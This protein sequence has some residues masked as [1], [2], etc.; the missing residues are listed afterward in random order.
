M[1][2]AVAEMK[3]K[4]AIDALGLAEAY[5]ALEKIADYIHIAK[6]GM[7]EQ[8]IEQAK[9]IKN[10]E[11]MISQEQNRIDQTNLQIKLNRNNTEELLKL[12]KVLEREKGKMEAI[13]EFG[14]EELFAG[15]ATK[16]ARLL[17]H[18]DSTHKSLQDNIKASSIWNKTLREVGL[19]KIADSAKSL[20]TW[21]GQ[22][23]LWA[24]MFTENMR[25]AS[26]W[27]DQNYELYGSLQSVANGVRNVQAKAG[28][29]QKEAEEAAKAV[30]EM[31]VDPKTFE[32][33]AVAVGTFAAST[34]VSADTTARLYKQM[35]ASGMS[36]KAMGQQY[37]TLRGAMAKYGLSS[38]DAGVMVKYLTDNHYQLLAAAGGSETRLNQMTAQFAA[39]AGAAKAAGMDTST[40]VDIFQKLTTDATQFV[41]LLGKGLMANNPAEMFLQ[42]GA[43]AEKVINQIKKMPFFLQDMVS[44]QRTG[45]GFQEL[46]QMDKMFTKFAESHHKTAAEMRL[47]MAAG[48]E[49]AESLGKE[50]NEM[51]RTEDAGYAFTVMLDELKNILV[52][53]IGPIVQFVAKIAEA[54]RWFFNLHPSIRITATIIIG[55]VGAFILL[56]SV[57]KTFRFIF[58]ELKS[59][60]T[61]G[62]TLFKKLAGVMNLTTAATE[63]MAAAAPAAAASG[64]GIRAFFQSFWG[65][66][67]KDVFLGILALGA[68][69]LVFAV[70]ARSLKGVDPASMIA[71]AIALGIMIAALWLLGKV[72]AGIAEAAPEIGIALVILGGLAGIMIAAG[73]AFKLFAEGMQELVKAFVMANAIEWEGIGKLSIAILAL[74]FALTVGGSLLVGGALFVAASWLVAKGINMLVEPLEKASKFQIGDFADG[75]AKLALGVNALA[76]SSYFRFGMPGVGAAAMVASG[77]KRIMGA[78]KG[79]NITEQVSSLSKL[80]AL[81]ATMA[82]SKWD[83]SNFE[84]AMMRVALTLNY[85]AFSLYN[86][87]GA[88]WL[89]KMTGLEELVNAAVL[90]VKTD[91]DDK[92]KETKRA[93]QNLAALGEVKEAIEKLRK[94]VEKIA[95]G[96]DMGKKVDK[97]Q[98]SIDTYLPEIAEGNRGLATSTNQ[99]SSGMG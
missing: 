23:A 73:Y 44:R 62:I 8:R 36:A 82:S 98:E 39:V 18:L 79:T 17:D 3:I 60:I 67:W 9:T 24:K 25:Q 97:I 45:M 12:E 92:A 51:R 11:T 89:A 38:K 32:D 4:L 86:L 48:G 35:Q 33:A 91:L 95:G 7:N 74:G 88:F 52:T 61:G 57:I 99:W 71:A 34:G 70:F 13:V 1:D 54:A 49:V 84:R 75:M 78:L 46:Q 5:G 96:G 83:M 26:L 40:V 68:L 76:A 21:G 53:L 90:T 58:G 55:V 63:G 80:L 77:L 47:V 85:L 87:A 15:Q 10:F 41:V 16:V 64:G 69:A 29:L 43:N 19:D 94:A 59:A 20:A 56:A 42:M 93:E 22:I 31:A 14:K 30:M 66:P 2:T 28:I 81:L 72:A 50:F 65:V 27:K 37:D 6:L